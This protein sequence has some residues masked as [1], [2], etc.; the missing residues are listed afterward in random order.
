MRATRMLVT[1]V[2]GNMIRR[3]VKIL[4]VFRA[5][6]TLGGGVAGSVSSVATAS[7]NPDILQQA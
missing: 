1:T 3:V 2:S 5:D 4:T 7:L 6:D